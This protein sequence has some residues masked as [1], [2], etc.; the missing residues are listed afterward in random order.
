MHLR[1]PRAFVVREGVPA[2]AGM[3]FPRGKRE[4]YIVYIIYMMYI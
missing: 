2:F 4:V 1:F 3:T